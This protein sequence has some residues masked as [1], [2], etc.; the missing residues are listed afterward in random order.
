MPA[1]NRAWDPTNISPKKDPPGENAVWTASF[2]TVWDR[3]RAALEVEDPVNQVHQVAPKA[4]P[5]DPDSL[6]PKLDTRPPMG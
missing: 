1:R 4:H 5:G 6:F 2:E 3:L